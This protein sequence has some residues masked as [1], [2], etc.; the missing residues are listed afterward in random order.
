MSVY[1]TC[2][3]ALAK[4]CFTLFARVD[5]QGKEYV[6]RYGPLLVVSN[7]LGNADVPLITVSVP[8]QV[9]FM[10]KRELYKGPI[11]SVLHGLGVFP[12]ERDGRDVGAVRWSLRQLENDRCVG[13]FP[14]GS[15][16]RNGEMRQ[17]SVGAAYLALKAQAPI[18]PVAVWGSEKIP[19]F[20]RTAFPFVR[21]GV[22]IGQAFTLPSIEGNPSRPLLAHLTDMMMSRV[23]AMLPE[24]YRGYYSLTQRHEGSERALPKVHRG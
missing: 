24:S 7:H 21:M 17:A 10:G 9:R 15:R 8:R 23:A 14:E 5:I 6:P 12:L 16:S 4:V 13:V 11:A 19:P 2:G 18:L 22:R 1:Y 20:W 3:N